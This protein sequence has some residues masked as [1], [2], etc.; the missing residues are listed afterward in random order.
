MKLKLLTEPN[1]APAMTLRWEEDPES[2][3]GIAILDTTGFLDLSEIFGTLVDMAGTVG[4]AIDKKV[5]IH[6]AGDVKPPERATVEFMGQPALN[7]RFN[8]RPMGS[9]PGRR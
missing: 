9:E 4:A 6:D 8:P 7:R 5:F 2:P 3:E 1:G